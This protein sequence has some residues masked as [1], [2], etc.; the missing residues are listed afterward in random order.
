MAAIEGSALKSWP[1]GRL[2]VKAKNAPID[3]DADFL[4]AS[5]IQ[6]PL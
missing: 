3:R 6:R 5:M 1:F 2:G 4:D